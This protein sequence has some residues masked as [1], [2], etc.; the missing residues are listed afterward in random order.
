MLCLFLSFFFLMLRRPPRSTLFPYTT[1]FRSLGKFGVSRVDRAPSLAGR[2][3]T[4]LRRPKPPAFGS[5]I[6]QPRAPKPPPRPVPPAPWAGPHA[7][8]LPDL[9][10]NHGK[11]IP[12]PRDGLVR[13]QP[14]QPPSEAGGSL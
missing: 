9:I 5:Q 3:D 6:V 13:V 12:A 10:G 1:L 11:R 7:R 8:A 4:T 2:V 14:P